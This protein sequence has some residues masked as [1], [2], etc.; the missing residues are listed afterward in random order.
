MYIDIIM[1]ELF[2]ALCVTVLLV[3]L[4]YCR[5]TYDNKLSAFLH[6]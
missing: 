6:V 2:A 1:C 5:R 3:T 4:Y